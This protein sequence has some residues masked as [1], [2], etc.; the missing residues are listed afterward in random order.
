MK[1]AYLLQQI[2]EQ[3]PIEVA[4]VQYAGLRLDKQRKGSYMLNCPFHDDRTPSFAIYVE[5]DRWYCY[6]GCGHGDTIDLLARVWGVSV[7][8]A[9]KRLANALGISN[10]IPGLDTNQEV[11]E[12][13]YKQKTMS[14]LASSFQQQLN[15][16]VDAYSRLYRLIDLELSSAKS[17]DDL[18]PI[19]HLIHI[20]C[21]VDRILDE[22]TSPDLETQLVGLTKA[23]RNDIE[24]FGKGNAV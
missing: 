9:I 3:L 11:M 20:R 7:G 10:K 18:E 5:T 16:Y 19:S 21:K 24:A 17:I 8:Q 2:K 12:A 4:A 13:A 1:T 15:Y 6:G 23:R 14:R 22:L